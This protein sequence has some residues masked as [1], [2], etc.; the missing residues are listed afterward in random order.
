M[1]DP[2][3]VLIDRGD[4]DFIVTALTRATLVVQIRTI[5]YGNPEEDKTCTRCFGSDGNCKHHQYVG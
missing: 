5:D 2:R 3:Y 4:I 1:I